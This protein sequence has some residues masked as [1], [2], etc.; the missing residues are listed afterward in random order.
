M[1]IIR[2]EDWY[3]FI[4]QERSWTKQIFKETDMLFT[5]VR[6]EKNKLCLLRLWRSIDSEPILLRVKTNV[7]FPDSTAEE[8]DFLVDTGA[9]VC[10]L[11]YEDVRKFPYVEDVDM[12]YGDGREE[13]TPMYAGTLEFAGRRF[14]GVAMIA[15]RKP[16]LGVNVLKFFEMK[17]EDEGH[18]E[19]KRATFKRF[20]NCN[21]L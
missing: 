19:W 13:E 15:S 4:R 1:G 2:E 12:A 11:A 10:A 18:R 7:V 21:I 9:S 5:L 16:I 14:S 20:P 6:R 17:T 8:R 3:N